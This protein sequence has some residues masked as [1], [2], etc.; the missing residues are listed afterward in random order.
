ML[1]AAERLATYGYSVD[2]QACRRFDQGLAIMRERKL[3]NLVVVALGSNASVSRAQIDS[4]LEMLGPYRRLELVLPRALGGG[5]DPD[6]RVMQEAAAR[7]PD[8]V[9][10]LDWPAHSAPHP[11]WFASDGLHL[12]ADGALAFA[13]F[14]AQSGT[15]GAQDSLGP[16][17]QP[18][19]PEPRREPRRPR[20]A[21]PRSSEAAVAVWRALGRT[22]AAV[23]GPVAGFVEQVV[24][25]WEGAPTDL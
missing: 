5:P 12:T 4:L 7:F 11:D 10:T 8:Q 19:A 13:E 6:G 25:G 2:A 17:P 16:P 20:P 22:I 3:P 24:G 15:A 23:M 18:A 9:S 21:E 1:A 14:V